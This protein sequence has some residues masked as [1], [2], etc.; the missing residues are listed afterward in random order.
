[1]KFDKVWLYCAD[2]FIE[3]GEIW[4][5]DWGWQGCWSSWEKGEL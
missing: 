5:S 2:S 1:M 3:E 4:A